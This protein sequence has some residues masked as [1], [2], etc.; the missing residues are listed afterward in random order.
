MINC[1]LDI[2]TIPAQGDAR[3]PFIATAIANYKPP[4]TL[5]KAQACSMLQLSAPATKAISKDDAI[6]QW[7]VMFGA[8]KSAMVAEHEWRKTALDGTH[9]EI[10]SIAWAVEDGVIDTS[11]RDI[12]GDTI[13]ERDMIRTFFVM[14]T[15]Q[16]NIAGLKGGSASMDKPYF[17]GHNIPFD[18][19]FIFRRAVILGIKP[20]FELPFAGYHGRDYFDNMMAWGGRGE[21]IGQDALCKALDIEGKPEGVTGSVVWD[22]VKDGKVDEVVI[23]NADDVDK[24]R[25][26]HKRLTFA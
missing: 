25:Q 23:Y 14:L 22:Y 5:T 15:T 17:I 9:G 8:A 10:I 6:E 1:Y 26:I 16:L 3:Q 13:N 19:K 24:A 11:W 20:P 21:Y 4:S 18:L 2:E 12:E 7:V